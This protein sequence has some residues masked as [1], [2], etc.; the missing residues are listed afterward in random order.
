MDILFIILI[1]I[2]M[3]LLMILY[4]MFLYSYIFYKFYVTNSV[5]KDF[6]KYLAF[7]NCDLGKL[8]KSRSKF[9]LYI[10]TESCILQRDE[11]K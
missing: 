3:E 4:D 9:I 5:N 1:S 7:I 11:G 10:S 8:S 6:I 2:L